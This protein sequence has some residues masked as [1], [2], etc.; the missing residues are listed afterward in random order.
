VGKKKRRAF[1]STFFSTYQAL[2]LMLCRSIL[3][4]SALCFAC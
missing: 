1:R 2:L 3:A 4:L